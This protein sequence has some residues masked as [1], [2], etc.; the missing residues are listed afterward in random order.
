MQVSVKF[1]IT[2]RIEG[3][4]TASKVGN[5]HTIQIFGQSYSN[6]DTEIPIVQLFISIQ[7]I[8]FLSVCCFKGQI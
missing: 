6:T 4:A 2:C 8:T 1:H 5:M 7:K 3:P